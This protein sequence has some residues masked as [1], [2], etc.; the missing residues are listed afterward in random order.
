METTKKIEIESQVQDL[1]KNDSLA[2][3]QVRYES[4]EAFLEGKLSSNASDVTLDVFSKPHVFR[5]ECL[6]HC[7]FR[8]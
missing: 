4:I 8:S 5:M 6:F 7:N 3:V 1:D 2:E